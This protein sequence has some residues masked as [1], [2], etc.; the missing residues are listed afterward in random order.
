[1]KDKIVLAQVALLLGWEKTVAD[2]L[3]F[4]A[5]TSWIE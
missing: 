2:V 4:E 3:A 1:M 5:L